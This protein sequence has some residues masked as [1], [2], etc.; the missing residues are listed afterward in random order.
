V[1]DGGG[2]ALV[3]WFGWD[4]DAAQDVAKVRRI[5]ANGALGRTLTLGPA[6]PAGVTPGLQLAVTPGG[7]GWVAWNDGSDDSVARLTPAGELDASDVV[8][9]SGTALY[10]TLGSNGDSAV[11]SRFEV[12]GP[13]SA[14]VSGVRLPASGALFGS[15]FATTEISVAGG[16]LPP[17]GRPLLAADGTI[18][19][20][21]TGGEITG[22]TTAQ[23]NVGYARFAPGATSAPVQQLPASGSLMGEMLPAL[24]PAPGN[25]TLVSW[26]RV[27][28]IITP[29]VETTTLAADGTVGPRLSTGLTASFVSSGA[30]P[31]FDRIVMPYGISDGALLGSTNQLL[32]GLGTLGV[33]RLDLVAPQLNATIPASGV[34]GQP[35]TFAANVSDGSVWWDFG[36]DSGS[37][38]AVVNHTY[39]TPGTYTVTVTATDA[40]GN[41]ATRSGQL[42]VSPPAVPPAPGARRT[43]A[44]LKLTSAVRSGGS[45]TIA[46]TTAS[47]ATGS[48]SLVYAQK[49]GRRTLSAR[50]SAKLAKGKFSVKLKLSKALAKTFRLKPTVTA[51]YAGDAATDGATVKRTVTVKRAARRAARRGGKKKR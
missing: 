13:S 42:T 10:A 35:L 15:G 50:M 51:T 17:A 5:S 9:A 20:A 41:V 11:L 32:P 18:T 37:R 12:S 30:T 23:L 31:A 2:N 40:A 22:P 6:G 36:D 38:R 48:V 8:P 27:D 3:A 28:N 45:V 25:G 46:G 19:V 34:T 43:A 24:A 7:T 21:W 47:S 26:L 39:G 29:S 4:A 49:N 14:H 33:K 44:D 1:V 16:S